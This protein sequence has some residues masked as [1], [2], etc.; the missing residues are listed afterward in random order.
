LKTNRQ[1]MHDAIVAGLPKAPSQQQVARRAG[2]V[3]MCRR[4]LQVCSTASLALNSCTPELQPTLACAGT[5]ANVV[6]HDIVL[7]LASVASYGMCSR[8]AAA[9]IK[10]HAAGTC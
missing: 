10:Q 3:S 7:L 5:A 1:I 6:S 2:A 4:L 9:S 8:Q